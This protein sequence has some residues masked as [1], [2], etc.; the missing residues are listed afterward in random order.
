[1]KGLHYDG[2]EYFWI[3]DAQLRMVVHPKADLIGQDLSGIADPTGKHLF[4]EVA[5]QVKRTGAGFV[6]YM[7]PK[8]GADQPVEK[9]SYVR[10]FEPWGWVIG[11]GVYTDDTLAQ[12]RAGLIAGGWPRTPRGA[13]RWD[14]HAHRARCCPAHSRFDQGDE[15]ARTGRLCG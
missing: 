2:Q 5:D 11:S 13:D 15:R 9:I 10:G 8:P 12:M 7:W 3:Q 1:M 6:P 4:V 14:R